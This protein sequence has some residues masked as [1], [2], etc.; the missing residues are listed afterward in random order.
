MN[1]VK[2]RRDSY[3]PAENVETMN[4][5]GPLLMQA[6]C[7]PFRQQTRRTSAARRLQVNSH[8]VS[9]GC[10]RGVL[11]R[12]SH[13]LKISFEKSGLSSVYMHMYMSYM[14]SEFDIARFRTNI[15]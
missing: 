14:R 15:F 1:G 3:Q 4:A 7:I 11:W 9:K 10:L 12:Q 13:S 2:I 8:E 6:H 5:S